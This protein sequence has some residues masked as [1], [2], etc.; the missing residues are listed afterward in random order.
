MYDYPHGRGFPDGTQSGPCSDIPGRIYSLCFR[1]KTSPP[2]VFLILN[3][4]KNQNWDGTW[5]H[6][7]HFLVNGAGTV[8]SISAHESCNKESSSQKMLVSSRALWVSDRG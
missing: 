7:S 3:T 1:K 8:F 2:Q 5:G 6:R 4:E